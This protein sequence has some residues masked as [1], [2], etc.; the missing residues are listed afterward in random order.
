M[1]YFDWRIIT[2]IFIFQSINFD[3]FLA[4]DDYSL[5]TFNY[6]IIYGLLLEIVKFDWSLVTKILLFQLVNFDYFFSQK[7]L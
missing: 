2:K 3:Y 5:V 1:V 7:W 6:S 4:K